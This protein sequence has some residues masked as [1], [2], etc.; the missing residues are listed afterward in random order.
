VALVALGCAC[1]APAPSLAAAQAPRPPALPGTPREKPGAIRPNR[2]TRILIPA[3]E[4]VDFA[5]DSVTVPFDLSTGWIVIPVEVNGS[6]PYSFVLDTGTPGHA[7]IAPDLASELT[8]PATGDA[9]SADGTIRSAKSVDLVRIDSLRVGDAVFRGLMAAAFLGSKPSLKAP[10][11]AADVGS[12]SDRSTPSTPA[13]PS[14]MPPADRRGILGFALFRTVLLTID[15]ASAQLVISHRALSPTDDHVTP[16][17]GTLDIARVSVEVGDVDMD[18]RLDTGDTGAFT[19]STETLRTL[20]TVSEPWLVGKARTINNE[21]DVQGVRLSGPL[22]LAG[23]RFD[24]T[25]A[26]FVDVFLGASLGEGI[27]RSFVLTFDESN[28]LVKL[29]RVGEG[30]LEAL[31]KRERAAAPR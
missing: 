31:A 13:P 15:Y 5:A 27:L 23:H 28:R 7:R 22:R 9:R 16:L 14:D 17:V 29:T 1:F 24:V 19:V 10:G 21:F 11:G 6:G 8:L 18:V 26:S 4:S 12:A 30:R 25:E 3:P 2:P 20:K